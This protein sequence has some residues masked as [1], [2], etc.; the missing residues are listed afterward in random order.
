VTHL[1]RIICDADLDYLGRDDFFVIGDQL[2]REFLHFGIVSSE[3]AWKEL[4]LKFLTSHHYHTQNS[5][6]L[7]EPVKQVNLK[8]LIA[9]E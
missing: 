3:K 2:R 8:K 5:A 6:E 4:Q 7:R 1:Q 9:G